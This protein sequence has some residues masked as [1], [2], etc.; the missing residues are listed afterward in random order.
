MEAAQIDNGNPVAG[1]EEEPM[2]GPGPAPR[3]RPKRPLQF[4]QAYLDSLPSANMYEK[5]YMHRDVVT[6]VAVSAADFFI[7]GSADGCI[8][9]SLLC[10]CLSSSRQ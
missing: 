10:N 7:S 4:E 5:S 8:T 6:H 9:T 3:R 2:V 1:E